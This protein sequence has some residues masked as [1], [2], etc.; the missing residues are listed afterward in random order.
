M[1]SNCKAPVMAGFRK[2]YA[3]PELSY[4]LARWPKDGKAVG[5][6][7]KGREGP[8]GHKIGKDRLRKI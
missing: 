3:F 1:G 4:E 6:S 8:K 2:V 7:D 5:F